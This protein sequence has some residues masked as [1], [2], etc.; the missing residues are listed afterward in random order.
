MRTNARK[1]LRAALCGGA[2]ATLTALSASAAQPEHGRARGM[3]GSHF[4]HGLLRELDLS[5]AQRDQIRGLFE[6][7]EATGVQR[8]SRE[9]RASL[10][11]AIESGADD[12]AIREMGRQL[13]EAEGESAVERAGIHRRVLAILTEE[14][15]QELQALKEEE[16]QEMEERRRRFEERRARRRDNPQR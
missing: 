3:R 15:R 5:D 9:A 16:K 2:L 8:R 11:D 12:E 14:Q 1:Y 6:E 10:H 4:G 7:M 13:G